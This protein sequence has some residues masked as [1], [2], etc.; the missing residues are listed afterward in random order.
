M[1]SP[2]KDASDTSA[3]ASPPLHGRKSNGGNLEY[4]ALLE[5][6]PD[7]IVVVNQSGKIVLVNAQAERL[8]GYGR[9]ELIGRPADILVSEHSRRQYRDRHVPFQAAVQEKPVV[10]GLELFGL[11][12]DGSE[13]PAEIRLSPLDT[14]QGILVSSAIRDISDRRRTEEDLRRLASIV[15]HS[16][17]AIIGKTLEGIITS[18]NAGAERMYGY[19][20]KEAIGKSVSMLVPINHPD[21]IPGVLER[22]KRGEVVDHFE[23][24]RVR[25]DGEEFPVE[26]TVSPIRDAMERIVGASTI[27]RDISE[28]KR[29]EEDL[30]RLAA[31]VESSD[32]AIIGRT[33]DG[34]VTHWNNAAQRI[35]GYS[36]AEIIGKPTSV[37]F[38]PDLFAE[39]AEML[40]K[41][42]HGNKVEKSDAV[43]V[44]HDGKEVHVALTHAPIKNA[45][46]HVIGISTVARDTSERRQTD[47]MIRKERDRA[48]QYL[49]IVDVILLALDLKGRIT[50][51]NRKDCSTLGWKEHELLGRDWVDT[52]LPAKIRDDL[53]RSFHNLIAGDLS[54]IENTVLTKSGS[55]RMIGWRNTLMRDGAGNITGALSSGEDITERKHLEQQLR[56]SQK[57]EAIGQLAGGIAHDFNNLLGVIL[58]YSEILLES[59]QLDIK[60]HSQCEEIQKAGERA[61]SLTRQLLVFSRQQVLAPNILNLNA[62]LVETEKMLRR[63]IGEHIDLRT[64]LDPMLGAVKA[65]PGQIGQVI[66]N[67]VV[68]ARDAM[69]EGGKLFIETSNAE[70]DDGYALRHPP[71]SAGRYVVLAVSD[72]GIGMDE[73]TQTHIFEPFFTTKEIGKGTGLGLSTVYGVV[74][75]SGGFV[76]VYSELG[77]GSVFKIYLPTVDE[78]V[79]LARPKKLAPQLLRGTE[80]VLLVEDE[81]SVRTLTRSLV[82]EAG[83]QVIEARSGT[84]ALEVTA[85]YS[86]PI[87]LLLTDVVMP[88]MNGPDLAERLAVTH[89][90]MKALCMSGY[91]GTFANLNGLVDRCVRLIEKPFS[92]EILLRMVRE[93]LESEVPVTR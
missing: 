46:G 53:R 84:D 90:N 36:A 34:T 45:E 30:S 50:L 91:T 11:R 81:E 19:L 62:V 15:E 29:R 83:Y 64:T 89:P 75:Q 57:M 40:E 66:M 1:E 44:R 49:D 68:N 58:G 74:N 33:L 43:R 20:A 25:K 80:T 6:A 86:G 39:I 35:Y 41:I 76:W 18:W 8:F 78:S 32:D 28:R 71:L 17:D 5:A 61:A 13:F 26:I 27:G 70:L 63:L 92:R 85:S 10:T 56:K 79:Q 24:L 14:N 22:L 12:K 65:D 48:Q 77:H 93:V 3:L 4:R 55:E 69:P 38:S 9:N 88:G 72:S 52:C 31:V 82:E 42:K 23:T 7:A 87:H 16:D 51:I 73:E 2:A 59:T 67:L 37:L 21:E 47:E 54:Y 60:S